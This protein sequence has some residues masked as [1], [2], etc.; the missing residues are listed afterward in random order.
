MASWKREGRFSD[1][2][3][4]VSH[5]IPIVPMEPTRHKSKKLSK[6]LPKVQFHHKNR[7][8]SSVQ[9][10]VITTTESTVIDPPCSVPTE[11]AD[12]EENEVCKV[13]T[14]DP[15]TYMH[16]G[17]Y[18]HPHVCGVSEKRTVWAQEVGL[19]GTGRLPP[20]EDGD[21]VPALA[22]PSKPHSV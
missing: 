16:H 3:E 14:V 11:I 18:T 10:I 7:A 19:D 17:T 4:E 2:W 21:R 6:R 5:T 1:S 12:I 9:E 22:F 15:L 13:D 20:V 8:A